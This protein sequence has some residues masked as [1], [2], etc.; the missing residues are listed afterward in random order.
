MRR[1]EEARRANRHRDD[2]HCMD[3]KSGYPFWAIKNGLMHEFPR[4]Q[5]DLRAD[6]VVLGGGLTG[7]LIA[8]ELARHGHDVIVVEQGE[9]GWGSTA[10]TTALLQYEIDTHLTELAERVGRDAA[11]L[12]YGACAAAIGKLQSLAAEVRDV[13]FARSH[14]LYFASRRRDLRSLQDECALRRRHGLPARWLDGAQV[15]E[16][17]GIH[18]PGAILSTLAARVDPYRFAARLL[19]RLQRAGTEVYS[20]TRVCTLQANSRGVRL[21]T[22]AGAAIRCKHLVMATGYASQEWLKQRVACNRSTYAFVSNPVDPEA[23]G[24]LRKTLVWESARPYL[25]LRTTLDHRL[26]VGGEDDAVDAPARRDAQVDPKARKLCQ[27]VARMFQHLPLEPAYAWAGTFAETD[28]GL[29]FFGS[30]PQHGPRVH[31]AMA[32]GGNGITYAVLGAEL[33]RAGIEGRRHALTD[34]FSFAR[35]K[36]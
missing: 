1:A 22:E 31:F 17:Y 36:R 15:L 18:C 30:H 7:A 34:L 35:L 23:L 5:R 33:L 6:V 19:R 28:D 9:V 13:G 26:M 16:R 27:R 20:H 21:Q 24:V 3:L 12:A 10:A 32:F 25:Y 29:P 8:A 14:S 2:G 4:V 11:V